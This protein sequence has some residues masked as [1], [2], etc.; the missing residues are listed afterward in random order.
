MI[1]LDGAL[2]RILKGASVTAV[3]RLPPASA[4]PMSDMP[5]RL[6][7]RRVLSLAA[8]WFREPGAPA[9]EG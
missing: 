5:L 3:M 2:S 6:H 4:V 8:V 1:T 7:V 9:P